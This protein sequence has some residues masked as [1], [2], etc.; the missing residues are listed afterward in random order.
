MSR[1]TI[2]TVVTDG[3]RDLPDAWPGLTAAFA[4]KEVFVALS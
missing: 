1:K 2:L 3:A 4:D